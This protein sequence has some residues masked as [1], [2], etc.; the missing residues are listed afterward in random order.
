M[1]LFHRGGRMISRWCRSVMTLSAS[2]LPRTIHTGSVNT[3][4]LV[5]LIE[6]W[7]SLPLEDQY[8]LVMSND[9]SNV[10]EMA[11]Q[12]GR[13]AI[14]SRDSYIAEAYK[15]FEDAIVLRADW[16]EAYIG[17]AFALRLLQQ[18]KMADADFAK[19]LSLDPEQAK[20]VFAEYCQL[21]QNA[22]KRRKD[23]TIPSNLYDLPADYDN[24]CSLFR[25]VNTNRNADSTN[26][27]PEL[28]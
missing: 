21:I 9:V 28:Y 25:K 12:K 14:Q 23:K 15:A 5:P 19:A 2:I 26:N 20:N 13:I 7:R 1:L 16:V 24:N 11:C 6:L 18:E 22:A 10:P 4:K 27:V 3:S 8:T 17:R